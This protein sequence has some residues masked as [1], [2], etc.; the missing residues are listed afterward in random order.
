MGVHYVVVCNEARELLN[1]DP[2]FGDGKRASLYGPFAHLIVFALSERARWYGGVRLVS[3]ANEDE[4]AAVVGYLDVTEEVQAAFLAQHR[5][6]D[7]APC[8]AAG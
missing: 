7:E 2:L 8:Q 1:P 3:D 4:W 6:E 5:P